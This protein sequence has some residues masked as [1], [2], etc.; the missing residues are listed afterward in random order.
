MLMRDRC[1][2]ELLN[3]MSDPKMTLSAP[4]TA[5]HSMRTSQVPLRPSE[6]GSVSGYGKGVEP[7]SIEDQGTAEK[8]SSLHRV[9]YNIVGKSGLYLFE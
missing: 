2:D 1:E 7:L 4:P 3:S 8:R 6:K 5:L 9:R